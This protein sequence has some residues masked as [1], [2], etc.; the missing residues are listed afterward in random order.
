[1]RNFSHISRAKR[2]LLLKRRMHRRRLAK[3][4]FQSPI[5]VLTSLAMLSVFA[6]TFVPH[7]FKPGDMVNDYA[8]P[9]VITALLAIYMLGSWILEKGNRVLFISSSVKM[10]LGSYLFLKPLV[11]YSIPSLI[12]MRTG[13]TLTV[14]DSAQKHKVSSKYCHYELNP[15]SLKSVHFQNCIEWKTYAA[16]PEGELA[17]D[18]EIVSSVWGTTLSGITRINHQPFPP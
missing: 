5:T 14:G 13:I 12:N 8:L 18:M 15:E 6:N 16:L 3:P 1:M 11:T 17:I 7:H 2:E 4:V 9:V 10:L